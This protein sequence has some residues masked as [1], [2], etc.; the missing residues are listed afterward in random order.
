M[1][2]TPKRAKKETISPASG[3]LGQM[4]N[5]PVLVVGDVM[6]DRFVYGRVDRISPESPVPVLITEREEEMLGGAGNALANLAGLGLRGAMVSVAGND[7]NGQ[8]IRAK[9]KQAGFD[10]DGILTDPARPSIMKTRF[11]AG[12][13]QLLR[14]DAESKTPY[15]PRIVK[16]IKDKV[17]AQIKNARAVIIS[18]YGKGLLE[19]DVTA[20]IIKLAHKNKIPVIVDPKG[21]D[22]SIYR[23]ADVITPN[24]KELFEA[25]NMP[26]D[27]D[28]QIIAAAEKI[29]KTC[30]V[31]AV[32][33]TRS[34]DGMT[35][36]Q[37]NAPPV[38]I[39]G[40][41]IEVYDVS[42]AGDAVVAVIGAAMATGANLVEAAHLA[43]LAGSIVVTKVG[44]APIR[45]S[46]LESALQDNGNVFAYADKKAPL[47]DDAAAAEQVR[48]WRTKNLTI[49]FTNGCFDILHAGHVSYL[50]AARGGCDRLIVG[51][52]CDSSVKLLKGAD[53]PVHDE[54]SRAAV[55]SA[56]AGVDMVV[57][58]GA[59]KPGDDNTAS[60]ILKL[61]K[62]DFY[63]KGGDYKESEIPEARTVKAFGGE[64][65]IM[66][67]FA[68]HSTTKSIRR[69]RAK[70][71]TATD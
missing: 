32:I 25:T 65:K 54:E 2:K 14:A 38:H 11:L 62:P 68:G 17:A 53:R 8:R 42:G 67:N 56:L 36:V 28:A 52:N 19:P 22:F 40:H 69:I 50:N 16:M 24:K 18:D 12:H 46:E 64:I 31:K 10:V 20:H 33:A 6:L 43:N 71:K 61:L 57:L 47:F 63:F 49:G 37:K 15:A 55:L 4:R 58:F 35:I 70:S 26:V 30:G 27:T 41:D 48:R 9:I 51:L 60:K 39:A 66:P 34:K 23:G 7:E 45:A 13:Q 21:R 1:K 44:T 5:L 3:I 59:K 29:I